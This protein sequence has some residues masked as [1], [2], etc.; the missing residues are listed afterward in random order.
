M[1][2]CTFCGYKIP[3]GTG[4]MYVRKD[5]RI[6]YFC[7]RRC[8]KNLLKLGRSPRNM[9]FTAD[10]KKAKQQTMAAL[11]HEAAKDITPETKPPR[12]KPT[13]KAKTAPTAK[14]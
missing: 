7:S 3:P 1:E 9:T 2:N 6:L 14:A 12:K 10:A 11:A 8:E 5:A 4:K 13:A